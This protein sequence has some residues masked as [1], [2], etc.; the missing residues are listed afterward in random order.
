MKNNK[1]TNRTNREWSQLFK[2][3]AASGLSM[4]GFCE[5]K[6]ISRN[7]FYSARL[8]L[9]AEPNSLYQANAAKHEV[10]TKPSPKRQNGQFIELSPGSGT[11]GPSPKSTIKIE[12]AEGIVISIGRQ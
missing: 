12:L 3:Q 5:Q 1:P 7:T 4:A 10:R 11:A 6:S 2:E 9:L 8:R